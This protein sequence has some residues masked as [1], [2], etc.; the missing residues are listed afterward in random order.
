MNFNLLYFPIHFEM[1]SVL[2][3]ITSTLEYV[4]PSVEE[5]IE[6]AFIGYKYSFEIYRRFNDKIQ[7]LE[8]ALLTSDGGIIL[9]VSMRWY[10][11]RMFI[12][13]FS[14]DIIF[15]KYSKVQYLL[16]TTSKTESSF[17]TLLILPYC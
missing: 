6:K 13:N 12:I 9:N 15:K 17:K 7:L 3:D 11:G 4:I 16:S 10:M 5:T 2:D 1:F 14:G 8:S